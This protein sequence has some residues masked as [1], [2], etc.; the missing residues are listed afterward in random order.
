MNIK[1]RLAAILAVAVFAQWAGAEIV[2]NT[3]GIGGD[4]VVRRS[5]ATEND[6]FLRIKNQS[7]DAEN[8]GNDRIGLI[9]FDLTSLAESITAA[10]VRLELPRGASTGQAGNT[11]DPGETLFLYGIPDLAADENFNE[12]TV[13]FANSPYMTGV[14]SVTDPRPGTDLTGNGVNDDLATLLDTFTFNAVSD[15]GDLVN[16][17]SNELVSFLQ[18]D[19]NNIATFILTVSQSNA[20]KT[21]VFVSDTGTE[22][23]PLHPTLLTN[24]DVP[25]GG[26]D[27]DM[28]NGT[29]IADFHI[30]RANYLTGTTHAEGDANLDGIVNHLDFF[31]WRT[32][33]LGGGGS[34]AGISWATV[35]E[36]ASCIMMLAGLLSS[37][38][39]RR[40]RR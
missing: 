38:N 3:A 12:A 18:A 37:L 5:G 26:T 24:A 40:R 8:S 21:A 39:V 20:T 15:A 2:D 17:Q 16:F 7:G 28:M 1:H 19:T 34:A 9:K 31:M 29:D 33:F 32:D 36:P 27:F 11:F 6:G 13:T 4:V 25:M 22:G 35:P 10:I 30:L 14:G 23:T